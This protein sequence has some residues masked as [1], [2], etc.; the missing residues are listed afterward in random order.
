MSTAALE[1][2]DAELYLASGATVTPGGPGYAALVQGQ[3]CFGQAARAMLRAQPRQ[4][5]RRYW[6]ELADTPLPVP[7]GAARTGAELVQA[8]LAALWALR[9][10]ADRALLVVPPGWSTVQL[11]LLLGIAGSAGIPVVGLVDAAV[12]AS[13]RPC[14]EASLWHLHGGLGQSVLSRIEQDA[15]GGVATVGVRH[16]IERCGLETLERGCA[17]FLARRF[18]ESSRFDPLHTAASEQ[19][20]F[21]ALPGWLAAAAR[22]ERLQLALSAGDRSYVATLEAADLRAQVARLCEPLLQRLRTLVSPRQPTVLQ[23]THGFSSYPG[24]LEALLT[25]PWCTVILLEPGAAA[26][27]ALRMRHGDPADSHVLTTS[28]PFDQPALVAVSPAAAPVRA[29]THVVHAGR[30]WRLGGRLLQVGSELAADEY[31]IRVGGQ[32]VSRRHCALV[33]EEGRIVLHDQSRYGTLL[34][35]HRVASAAVLQPGDV[36]GIGQPPRELILVAEMEDGS[37]GPP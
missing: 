34:N 18:V 5:H 33:L 35:G 36:I 6:A 1:L 25:L 2:N 27:G 24:A 19:Q 31:G 22:E 3:L 23:V 32:G 8:Q 12:A 26:S 11:G 4:A 29:P 9:G 15:A 28:L 20:L 14:P 21:D 30:A 7:L 17:E 16:V 10:A 37:H 13:R